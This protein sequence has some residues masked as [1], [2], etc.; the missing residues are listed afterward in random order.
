MRSAFKKANRKQINLSTTN[1]RA[2]SQILG[3]STSR[4]DSVSVSILSFLSN[5]S[6][7]SSNSK[8]LGS[9]AWFWATKCCQWLDFGNILFLELKL[10]NVCVCVNFAN[11]GR[12][13]HR[14]LYS[15]WSHLRCHRGWRRRRRTQSKWRFFKLALFPI[16][17][18]FKVKGSAFLEVS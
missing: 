18:T 17:R 13:P 12:E 8:K 15:Y 7:L 14:W 4:D 2:F 6:Y 10:T 11:L 3:N 16:I 9:Q 5:F 1:T